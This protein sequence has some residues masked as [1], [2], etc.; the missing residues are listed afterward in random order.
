VGVTHLEEAR[1]FGELGNVAFEG[2]RAE[3]IVLATVGAHTIRVPVFIR[4]V[5]G[6]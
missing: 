3:L 4:V 2:K 6:A 5:R 1:A